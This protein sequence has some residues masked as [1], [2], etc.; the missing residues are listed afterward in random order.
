MQG[1]GKRAGGPAEHL[2]LEPVPSRASHREGECLLSRGS[3]RAVPLQKA[4]GEARPG[5]R[6]WGR[7]HW[8]RS[9]SPCS[10]TAQATAIL[11]GVAGKL[12]LRPPGLRLRETSCPYPLHRLGPSF[13]FPLSPG[14][15]GFGG[16]SQG[17]VLEKRVGG[18]L[19]S[20]PCCSRWCR[21]GN[22]GP[23]ETCPGSSRAL[24]IGPLIRLLPLP[25][26]FA[27]PS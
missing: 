2:P 9:L 3:H 21:L 10:L 8:D 5:S 22:P 27:A 6:G 26:D 1:G 7:G 18:K 13:S 14:F 15:G 16:A 4:E 11:T 19:S 23:G 20:L 24:V 25:W 17:A 12:T